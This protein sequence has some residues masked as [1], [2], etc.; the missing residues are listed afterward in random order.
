MPHLAQVN[1]GWM[2]WPLNDPRMAAFRDQVPAINALAD[3]SP[4][5]VWRYQ[6]VG[7]HAMGT[8]VLEDPLVLY[9]CSIW[10]T[11]EDL[12]RYVFTTGHHDLFRRR[13]EWFQAPPNG[14]PLNVC[15]WLPPGTLVS[16]DEGMW[17]WNQL[18][19][20]GPSPP[21][22]TL[23]EAYAPDGTLLPQGWRKACIDHGGHP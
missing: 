14:W 23:Q 9:N 4:G 8:R 20:H 2:R 10:R 7:G 16:V 12:W 19:V 1:L 6:D 3:R 18:R 22:F 21:Y 17:R 13:R 11:L 5:F 15:W